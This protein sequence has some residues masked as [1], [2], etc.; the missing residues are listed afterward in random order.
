[1]ADAPND[2]YQDKLKD[3]GHAFDGIQEYDNNLPRWWLWLFIGTIVWSAWYLPFYAFG[4]GKVGPEKLADDMAALAADRAKAAGP[5][6]DE[7]GL[8]QIANDPAR[9]AAGKALWNSTGCFACHGPEGLGLVGPNLRDEHWICEPTMTGI[10]GVIENGGRPGKGMQPF[11]Q[12]GKDGIRDLAAFIVSLNREGRKD[13][14]A[15]PAGA[16]EKAV[17][18]DW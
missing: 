7:A 18:L 6:M 8:R 11:P 16:D 9:A 17:A 12:L 10:T 5:V 13:N 3:D 4:P 15:K 14:P 1:M 2:P